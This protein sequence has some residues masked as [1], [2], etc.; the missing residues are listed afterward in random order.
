MNQIKSYFIFLFFLC[1]LGCRKDVGLLPTKNVNEPKIVQSDTIDF[2]CVTFPK[3]FNPP[4]DSVTYPT[5][6]MMYW[7][8]RPGTK[9]EVVYTLGTQIWTYNFITRQRYFISNNLVYL[10]VC[11]SSG[12]ILYSDF[13]DQCVYKIKTNGDSLTRLTFDGSIGG[14]WNYNGTAIYYFCEAKNILYKINTDGKKLDS[15]SNIPVQFTAFSKS[16]DKIY[17]GKVF[18][19]LFSIVCF[20]V[21]AKKETVI[22]NNLPSGNM[23]IDDSEEN[24]YIRDFS[25]FLKYNILSKKIDTLYKDC[26]NLL[27]TWPS[28]SAGTNK[29]TIGC[30]FAKFLDPKTD[31]NIKKP[32]LLKW[33]K[34]FQIDVNDP[35][36]KLE[37]V[38]L[39]P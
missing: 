3:W 27:W 23:T 31:P 11:N 9:V 6:Q 38:N 4:P 12:W 32:K 18:N 25:T 34:A 16:S 14:H 13:K 37:E 30:I 35:T 36:H 1:L 33:T 26:D 22:T 10:P 21:L 39:F 15:L 28:I 17:Y 5:K 8:Y 7:Q 29:V 24:L 20:D 2:S 19:G